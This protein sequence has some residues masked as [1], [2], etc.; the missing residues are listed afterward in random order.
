MAKKVMASFLSKECAI[1]STSIYGNKATKK[2]LST[3]VKKLY[4]QQSWN[5]IHKVKEDKAKLL[6]D[7]GGSWLHV[8]AKKGQ[9]DVVQKLLATRCCNTNVALTNGATALCAAVTHGHVETVQA[10]LEGGAS[11]DVEYDNG[12]TPL[13]YAASAGYSLIVNE[14]LAKDAVVN[15]SLRENGATPLSIAV[16]KGY[17]DIVQALLQKGAQVNVS[18]GDGVTPLYYAVYS[19]NRAIV[20]ELLASLH[21]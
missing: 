5:E 16:E 17:L 1:F 8:A 15:V 14:L 4:D 12:M 6:D 7:N 9:V 20:K 18:Y 13:Y 19:G 11:A 2:T 3:L 21:G 10:L